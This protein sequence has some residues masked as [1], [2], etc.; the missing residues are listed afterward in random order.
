MFQVFRAMLGRGDNPSEP[1]SSAT[2]ATA[3]QS[4]TALGD[5]S[6]LADLTFNFGLAG[7]ADVAT[8]PA[9]Q[10]ASCAAA[11]PDGA[12]HAEKLTG[13]I[14]STRRFDRLREV[15]QALAEADV[16]S[17]KLAID[18]AQSLIELQQFDAALSSLAGTAAKYKDDEYA[19]GEVAGLRGRIFKQIYLDGG[20]AEPA[21]LQQ[22]IEYYRGM[23]ASR[24]SIYHGANTVALAY[25]AHEQGIELPAGSGLSRSVHVAD[26]A[27][28][29]IREVRMLDDQ[30]KA[31]AWDFASAAEA[32]IALNDID[33]ARHYFRKYAYQAD[34]FALNGTIRQLQEV[35]QIVPG[36][37][38]FGALLTALR[39]KLAT[40]QDGEFE[41][42]D[43]ERTLLEEWRTQSLLGR[44]DYEF[45]KSLFAG[46]G[47]KTDFQVMTGTF[48]ELRPIDWVLQSQVWTSS[49]ARIEKTNGSERTPCGTGF[50]MAGGL[51]NPSWG[52]RP[53]LVTCEHVVS[54]NPPSRLGNAIGPEQGVANFTKLDGGRVLRLGGRESI[55]WSSARRDGH[56]ITI[57]EAPQG[58]PHSARTVDLIHPT[59][60]PPQDGTSMIGEV[61]VLGHP[62]GQDLSMPF[63]SFHLIDHDAPSPHDPAFA[64]PVKLQYKTA[65]MPGSSGS[66]VFN[67]ENWQ[68]VGVHHRGGRLRRLRR[69]GGRVMANQANWIV[70]V[71]KAVQR[72]LANP[73]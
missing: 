34:G 39:V 32:A 36:E 28:E 54:A 2:L 63:S 14:M 67:A 47:D 19:R 35:W 42:D 51:L 69:R 64:E 23:W 40:R 53:V 52:E 57:L 3:E 46:N 71:Q 33:I 31:K 45:V 70:S 1:A 41:L 55:L 56:D 25:L 7:D 59:L 68:L 6:E 43:L 26:L 37:G 27:E 60:A 13:R 61:V 17:P 30:G 8:D 10:F 48:D 20:G 4:P 16:A 12:S 49:I 11:L 18:H 62:K 65:T 22:G 21:D 15:S 5:V 38:D 58:L 9:G 50:L 66:P 44:G 24:R 73:S 29:I 72:D